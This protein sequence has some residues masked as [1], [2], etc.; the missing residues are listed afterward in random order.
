M[1]KLFPPMS[2][3][4]T[5]L[6]FRTSVISYSQL[7]LSECLPS[8]HLFPPLMSPK[9]LPKYSSPK[10]SS[11]CDS[12]LSTNW[13][14][15]PTSLISNTSLVWFYLYLPLLVKTQPWTELSF[16]T[17]PRHTLHFPLPQQRSFCS[18]QTRSMNAFPQSWYHVASRHFLMILST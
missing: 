5:L 13:I 7:L 16:E 17:F 11:S 1:P 9:L 12:L 6:W 8:F 18:H 2:F 3:P 10:H 15:S 14:L 4:L